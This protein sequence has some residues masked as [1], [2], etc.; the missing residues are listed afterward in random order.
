MQSES[1]R[2]VWITGASGGIGEA[3]AKWF[4]GK[5]WRV[6]ISARRVGELNKVAEQLPEQAN[7]MVLP[8]DVTQYD[9]FPELTQ[10]V[11]DKFGRI[12]C[13]ILNA[14]ISHRSYIRDTNFEVFKKMIDVNYLGSVAH[15]LA[16]IPEFKKAGQGHFV[17]ISSLMGKFSSPGRAGYSGS[18]HALHGFF[19]GLRMEEHPHTRVTMVCPGFV[20]TDVTANALTADGSPQGT[21]DDT[22]AKGVPVEKAARIIGKAILKGKKEIAFGGFEKTG[23]YIKRFF[24]GLL[25]SLVLKNRKK[26][27]LEDKKQDT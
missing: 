16:V 10:K 27:E 22:T 5:N 1:S 24:P 2:V 20:Q 14:G 11:L 26:W 25:D 9:Q 23:L 18:K 19:D 12:D 4:A 17:V 13:C 21:I 3:L 15:A 6:V 7:I 8:L